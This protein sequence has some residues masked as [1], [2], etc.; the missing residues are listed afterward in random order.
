M[1]FEGFRRPVTQ[2]A[3][4]KTQKMTP[5]EKLLVGWFGLNGHLI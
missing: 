2:I 3:A 1:C 5:S 4:V